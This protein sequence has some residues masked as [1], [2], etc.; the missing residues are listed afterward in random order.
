MPSTPKVQRYNVTPSSLDVG[1]QAGGAEAETAEYLARRDQEYRRAMRIRSE[2]PLADDRIAAAV[3]W[4]AGY[5]DDDDGGV[6]AAA[7]PLE[8]PY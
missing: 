4:P 6:G 2:D 3:A 7:V 1:V 8:P 5:D